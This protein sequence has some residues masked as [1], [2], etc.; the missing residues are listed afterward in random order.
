MHTMKQAMNVVIRVALI[1]TVMVNALIPTV[2]LAKPEITAPNIL[3]TPAERTLPDQP[4]SF[5]E[6]IVDTDSA[7]H[8]SSFT[9][10]PEPKNPLR[11]PIEFHITTSKEK[12]G[13]DRTITIRVDIR[14][15]SGDEISNIRYYDTLNGEVKYISSADSSV[16]FNP[17]TGVVAFTKNNLEDGEKLSFSYSV[18]VNNNPEKLVINT[19]ELEYDRNGEIIAQTTS[20]GHVTSSNLLNRNSL[21]L[22]PDRSGDKWA[23]AGRYSLYLDEEVISQDVMASITSSEHREN[24]PALQFDIDLIKTSAPIT[25]SEG[26]LQEQNINLLTPLETEFKKPAY[27]EINLDDYFD[28]KNVPAGQE[29][30]VATYDESLD[31]WVKVPIVN[32]DPISNSVTIAAAHFSTWG[33]G[34]GSSLPKNGANVLLFDQ[35]YTSLFTGA[36]RYSIPIWAPPGR[37]G[38]SPAVSLSY[39][40]ATM[41]GLLGDVQAPWVG[42]GWNIDSIEIVRK[43]TTSSNGYG[44]V[45]DFALTLNGSAYKLIQDTV[46]P[47]RYYTDH[48]S[49][50]Y[51]ERHNYA[52]GNAQWNGSFPTNDTGEW[53]EVVTTDGTRY[54]IGWNKDA[55]QLALMYGYKCTSNGSNCLTPDGAYASLGYA[56]LANNLVALRWRVDL[57]RDTHGNTIQYHYTESQPSGGTT[58][59]TFDRESYLE[60]YLLY[61]F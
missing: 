48:D 60:N 22:V 47:S 46:T 31:I 44:Y 34:L 39:S 1:I 15:N 8:P 59:A 61:R 54:R 18:Q 52:N 45:N 36:S 19:A 11:D 14:N 51:I 58:I 12:I 20:F 53:W 25:T 23:S 55:E 28:L 40:S 56:G 38:M 10:T 32:M 42:A 4:P 41:N 33:V 5:Y 17:T 49:F 30:F 35:P 50:L 43:I 26:G 27:L 13:D 24:G 16:R 7:L 6:P 21:V 37:A 29:A 9:D 2:A 57:I 3:E